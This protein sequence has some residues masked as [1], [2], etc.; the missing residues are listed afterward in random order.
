[1]GARLSP[2]QLRIMAGPIFMPHYRPPYNEQIKISHI[3]G[4][5]ER[6]GNNITSWHLPH[7]EVHGLPSGPHSHQH[8]DVSLNEDQIEG[9]DILPNTRAS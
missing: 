6:R 3:I 7:R 5:N 8:S 2:G 1:M 4:Q 9:T